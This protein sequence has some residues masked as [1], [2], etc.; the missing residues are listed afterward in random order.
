[1]VYCDMD[2][3]MYLYDYGMFEK[4]P[5]GQNW[6]DVG[7]H[8][9]LKCEVDG[10]A[11]KFLQ[12]L[13][14]YIGSDLCVLTSVDASCKEIENEHIF[15]K[16]KRV[17]ED[18]P[19][20]SLCNF[21][22]CASEKRNAISKIKGMNLSKSDILIDDYNK[23]LYAW[24]NAGG[25]SI[26]YINGVNSVGDWPGVFIDSNTMTVDEA[27]EIFLKTWYESY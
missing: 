25:T 22:A 5:V 18:Y 9:F 10:F 2:G 4:K 27:I 1:M 8:A 7:S 19:F 14:R 12:R 6:N 24:Q 13:S 23:N 16:M 3:F 26:K 17:A 21:M 15:D 20:M 11:H